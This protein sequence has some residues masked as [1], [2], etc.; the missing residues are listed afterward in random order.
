MKQLRILQLNKLL[1]DMQSEKAAVIRRRRRNLK[2][3]EIMPALVCRQ[4]LLQLHE[5]LEKTAVG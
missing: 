3:P 5:V 4:R 1:R 2:N